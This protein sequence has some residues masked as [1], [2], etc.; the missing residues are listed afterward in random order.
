M[1]N[2]KNMKESQRVENIRMG[3]TQEGWNEKKREGMKGKKR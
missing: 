1:D 3:I 2:R